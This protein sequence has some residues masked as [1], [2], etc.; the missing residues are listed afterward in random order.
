MV[1]S[2]VLK[3][4]TL[5]PHVVGSSRQRPLDPA[6]FID[7]L[8]VFD[9]VDVARLISR[10]LFEDF[11][12]SGRRLP[13]GKHFPAA[14]MVGNQSEDVEVRQCLSRR[15]ADLPEHS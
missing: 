11:E 6:R 2:S 13:V 10:T 15:F 8:I 9:A 3:Q 7:V 1:E 14:P 5:L 4:S 12:N